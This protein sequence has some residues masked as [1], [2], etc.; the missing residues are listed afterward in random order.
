MQERTRP[1]RPSVPEGE[2]TRPYGLSMRPAAIEGLRAMSRT[3]GRS[4]GAVLE[5]ALDLEEK[6]QARKIG[7]GGA[8][9]AAHLKSEFGH[10]DGTTRDSEHTTLFEA[11]ANG[12]QYFAQLT[13]R[14][15]YRIGVHGKSAEAYLKGRNPNIVPAM[16]KEFFV[17]VDTGD[18]M[19]LRIA[20]PCHICMEMHEFVATHLDL[21]CPHCG[22]PMHRVKDGGVPLDAC[23]IHP[24]H[25]IPVEAAP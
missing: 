22:S 24:E 13:H 18:N 25:V 5:H 14:A 3:Q 21:R 4:M 9:L 6:D 10:F 11:V 1:G 7:I 20:H 23:D 17:R 15:L 2:R 16:R 19:L 8:A 12:T